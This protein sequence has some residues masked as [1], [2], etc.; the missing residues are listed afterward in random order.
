M[1]EILRIGWKTLLALS[2]T[3]FKNIFYQPV[4]D[5]ETWSVRLD[6]AEQAGTLAQHSSL[7]PQGYRQLTR[8]HLVGCACVKGPGTELA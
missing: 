4:L 2:K 5:C 3:L 8:Y 1:I 7:S 6:V